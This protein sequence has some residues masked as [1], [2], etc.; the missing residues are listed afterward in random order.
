PAPEEALDPVPAAGGAPRT[1]LE[2]AIAGIWREVLGVEQVGIEDNFFD[3]G[4]HSLLLVRVHS[5]LQKLLDREVPVVDLFNHP[6]IAALARHLGDR[7]PGQRQED[8]AVLAAARQRG[9]EQ[10]EG[11]GGG[12]EGI[13][14][15]GLAGRFP[16]AADVEELWANLRA[17]REC[18]RA[19]SDEELLAAGVPPQVL[20]R[21]DY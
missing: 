19:F 5:R 16:G 10:R 3:R 14:I 4:G 8:D 20:A 13:A 6:T 12:Q 21:P 18:I 15:V 2:Q 9:R 1:G 11:T 7:P 17:G